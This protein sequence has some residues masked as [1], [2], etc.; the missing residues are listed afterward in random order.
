MELDRSDGFTLIEMILVMVIVG[1]LL[2]VA[3][4]KFINLVDNH[5][6]SSRC[7][8]ARGSINSAL[9]VTYAAI[10]ISDPG[11]EGWLQ[12]ATLA[13][14]DD[15]MFATGAVPGC[16]QHGTFTIVNGQAICSI[17]GQ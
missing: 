5:V 6:E 14:L 3:V 9:S 2:G 12:S 1:I 17:H 15:T 16:P 10:I 4:P 13:A 8:S 7:A 11:Q